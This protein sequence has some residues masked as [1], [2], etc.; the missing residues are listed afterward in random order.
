[1]RE[2]ESGHLV[3]APGEF[4]NQPAGTA[5]GFGTGEFARIGN[6]VA[7]VLHAMVA[8]DDGVVAD[9][10]RGEVR[11]LVAGFPIYED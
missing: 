11:D 5:R 4:G 2:I 6:W 1:L 9:R 7:D 3:T 8:G 10:V